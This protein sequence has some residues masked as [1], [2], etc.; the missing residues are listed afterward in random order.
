MQICKQPSK[1]STMFWNQVH[2]VDSKLSTFYVS[3]LMSVKICNYPWHAIYLYHQPCNCQGY[4]DKLIMKYSS[5]NQDCI[6]KT[7][8][9]FSV[10]VFCMIGQKRQSPDEWRPSF[11]YYVCILRA[12]ATLFEAFMDC[13]RLSSV[14]QFIV[15]CTGCIFGIK[16]VFFLTRR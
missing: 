10:H 15:A 8:K 7:L 4:R 2:K 9:S 6:G 14:K 5:A 11:V 13:T 3:S 16:G 12:V 1:S